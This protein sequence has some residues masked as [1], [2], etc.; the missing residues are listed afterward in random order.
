MKTRTGWVIC[1]VADQTWTYLAKP[2]GGEGHVFTI[3]PREALIIRA[4]GR[5]EAA[6]KASAILGHPVGLGLARPGMRRVHTL[7]PGLGAP[8]PSQSH[9][10][11]PS[12][13][14]EWI[15]FVRDV[16]AFRNGPPTW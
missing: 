1:D 5:E 15:E 13:P 3:E 16:R 9:A 6:R 14:D 4:T 8:L 7:A 11:G 2:D 10:D 12:D